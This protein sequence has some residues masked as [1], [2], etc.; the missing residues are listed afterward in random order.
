MTAAGERAYKAHCAALRALPDG[1][2][3]E[4]DPAAGHGV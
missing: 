1:A 4:Q 3:I 2:G